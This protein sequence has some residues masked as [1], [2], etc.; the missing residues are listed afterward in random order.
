MEAREMAP[1]LRAHSALAKDSISVPSTY[2]RRLI[3]TFNSSLGRY[4]AFFWLLK[5]STLSDTHLHI[6]KKKIKSF[7]N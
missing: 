5:I 6:I 1:Q 7:K 3:T 4:D 2:T